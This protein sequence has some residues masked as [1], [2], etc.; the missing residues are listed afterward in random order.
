MGAATEALYNAAYSIWN[1]LITA[2][3]TLFTTSSV[4]ANGDVY[5]TCKALFNAITDIS[6]PIA[7]T[8][9][10][11]AIVK[12]VVSSPPDQQTKRLLLDGLKFVILLGIIANLWEIMGYVMEIADGV[13]SK[14]AETTGDSTYLLSV[15]DDLKELLEEDEGSIGF[16]LFHFDDW[17]SE[18]KAILGSQI[19]LLVSGFFTI[20]IVVASGVSVLSSAFQRILKPLV[21]LPF[22][23]ITV[24]MASGSNEAERVT[25]SYIKS[26]FGICLSGAFMVICVKLGAAL[27]NG[28]LISF[29]TSTVTRNEKALLL[30]VQNAISPIVIAGLVK[31]ADS[32]ISR[33]L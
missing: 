32:T 8:F 5:N 25:S 7:T 30:S 27:V 24:A 18:K 33:F 23:S 1:N 6:L 17:F 4:N 11:I 9:F 15:S 29:D 31:T 16:S 21:V 10:L 22:A 19:M 14:F 28:G 12:D 2:A 20:I 13:T 26:F 3:M